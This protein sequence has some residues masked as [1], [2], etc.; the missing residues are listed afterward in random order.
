[1]CTHGINPVFL[2]KCL[3]PIVSK[4]LKQKGE[5]C[6]FSR[7]DD[8]GNCDQGLECD[9]FVE[10]ACGVCILKPG[11]LYEISEGSPL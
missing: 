10:D 1:M 3:S 8:C 7:L 2:F 4:S 9:T 5:S 11:E 6:G